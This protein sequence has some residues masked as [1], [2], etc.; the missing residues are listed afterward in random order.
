VVSSDLKQSNKG[1][2][3]TVELLD[4]DTADGDEPFT[5]Q[6]SHAQVADMGAST[7]ATVTI[8]D[9]LDSDGGGGSS[10]GLF[11]FSWIT[12]GLVLIGLFGRVVRKTH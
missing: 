10:N 12:V 2:T 11:S 8:S 3:F 4:D 9:T 5:V 6:L 1:Q 7:F